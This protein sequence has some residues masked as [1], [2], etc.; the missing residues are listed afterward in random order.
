MRTLKFVQ[1]IKSSINLLKMIL[2]YFSWSTEIA[3]SDDDT[4]VE[5]KIFE[6]EE[7]VEGGLSQAE[8]A[9]IEMEKLYKERK[10]DD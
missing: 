4:G 9:L 6:L 1:N 8:E 10:N 5:S 2:E 3:I 7:I